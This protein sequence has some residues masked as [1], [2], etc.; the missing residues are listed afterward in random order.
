MKRS[1]KISDKVGKRPIVDVEALNLRTPTLKKIR[2]LMKT[3]PGLMSGYELK[4]LN[5][6][7]QKSV[8]EIEE[9]DGLTKESVYA[10]FRRLRERRRLF[11]IYLKIFNNL[12][13]DEDFH[14]IMTP[15]PTR[16]E[17]DLG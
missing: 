11:R 8:L 6:Y 10:V 17:E 2:E 14:R 9:E 12:S 7:K 3:Y 5:L 13:R 15:L 4:V 1:K 16:E